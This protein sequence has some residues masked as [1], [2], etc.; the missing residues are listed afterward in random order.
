MNTAGMRRAIHRLSRMV[1]WT[2]LRCRRIGGFEVCLKL[3]YVNPAGSHKDRIAVSMVE[4]A[5]EN[6]DLKGY[7]CIAEASS[8]NTAVSVAWVSHYLGLKSV[9][10]VT[11]AALP[12]KRDMIRFLGGEVVEVPSGEGRVI[13]VEDAERRGCLMLNQD[14]NEANMLAHYNGTGGEVLLQTDGEIDAFVMGVGTGGTI[15]GVGSRLKE[16]LG[17]VV[18]AAV[19]PSGSVLGGGDGVG[20]VIPGLS[21]SEVPGLYRARVGIVDSVIPVSLD[22]AVRGVKEL[23]EYTG[24]MAGLS[25]GAA[26]TGIYRAVE[27]GLIDKSARVVVIAADRLVD[28]LSLLRGY[29]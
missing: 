20:D 23:I 17:H 27:D 14:S 19:T 9:L 12:S 3:E 16:E 21:S 8:G 28:Y 5:L 25:T 22:E 11:P 4:A 18:V 6:G 24:V 15:T 29:Y 26:L 10:Y 1:G 7:D 13:A 2:P